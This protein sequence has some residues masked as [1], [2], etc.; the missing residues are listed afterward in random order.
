MLIRVASYFPPLC[1]RFIEAVPTSFPAIKRYLMSILPLLAIWL[2]RCPKGQMPND[3]LLKTRAVR[4]LTSLL[5]SK[6]KIY[7]YLLNILERKL[8]KAI[9]KSFPIGADIVTTRQCNLNCIMCIKYRSS[10]PHIMPI[11]LFERIA[12]Q[13]FRRLLYVRFCSGGEHFLH[14]SF[15]RM[16]EICAERG[17]LAS[18]LSNGMLISDEWIELIVDESSVWSLSISFDGA[19]K[20]TFEAI[21]RNAD[22]EAVLENISKIVEAK[23]L[24]R[25]RFPILS[26]RYTVMRSNVQELPQ[27]VSLAHRIGVNF[28]TVGYLITPTGMDREESLW[29]HPE[30]TRKHFAKA[31]ALSEELGFDLRLPGLIDEQTLTSSTS[32]CILPWSQIYVDPNGDVRLC[33]DAWDEEGV[34]GNISDEDFTSIWNNDRYQEVRRSIVGGNPIYHRCVNCPALSYDPAQREMHFHKTQ[35]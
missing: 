3:L 5:R 6:E 8:G 20:G 11:A 15:R 25:K 26:L 34:I 24:R 19:T 30:L 35:A 17:C 16:L 29:M 32:M 10:P 18:I 14:E 2:K 21:R 7:N 33:C 1:R 4:E 28:V 13:L 9:L 23:R 31:R 12:N 22:Y 27:L